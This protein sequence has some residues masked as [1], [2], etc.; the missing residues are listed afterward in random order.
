LAVF[1]FTISFPECYTRS[2]RKKHFP[3]I[4]YHY[5][6]RRIDAQGKAI[7]TQFTAYFDG[8]EYPMKGNPEADAVSLKRI[9]RST[10]ESLNLKAGKIIYRNRR[11]ISADGKVLT[12]TAQSTNAKGETLTDILVFDKK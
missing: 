9:D 12:I 6:A 1:L 8:K 11:T 5:T 3:I 10:H 2:R 7:V 4:H